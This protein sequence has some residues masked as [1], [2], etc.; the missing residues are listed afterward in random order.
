M[1]IFQ[2][3]TE[4][5][6][7]MNRLVEDLGCQCGECTTDNDAADFADDCDAFDRMCA[8]DAI[9]AEYEAIL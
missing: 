8:V 3:H 1:T 9:N 2:E 6:S 4:C 7:R 5:M